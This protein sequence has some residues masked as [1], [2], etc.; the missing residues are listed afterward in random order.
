MNFRASK[1]KKCA[2]N[3]KGSVAFELAIGAT[4]TICIV[5]FAL[6]ICFAMISYGINDH[7]C[8]D[9]ARAAAQGA[10]FT[11]ANKAAR[12]IVKTY[13][14]NNGLTAPITV[15]SVS[16]VDFFGNTPVG[17]SPFVTV[18]TRTEATMPAPI[19]F[20]GK[21]IFGRTIPVQKQYTFPIVRLTVNPNA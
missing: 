18:T 11:E 15:V 19:E 8:R 3:N 7:A 9:A 4:I 13:N 20:M 17:L 2:R 14:S 10:N 21:Q 16:Y 5:A 12:A 1:S 6:N